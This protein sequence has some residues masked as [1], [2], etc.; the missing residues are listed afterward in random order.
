MRN[1]SHKIGNAFMLCLWRCMSY[2]KALEGY[3]V[4][5]AL[6]N[7]KEAW[8]LRTGRAYFVDGSDISLVL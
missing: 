8:C 7:G 1:K 2:V 5:F 3:R 6:V 4:S